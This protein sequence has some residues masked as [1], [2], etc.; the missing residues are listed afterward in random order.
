M[1]LK[2]YFNQLPHGSKHEFAKQLGITKTWLSLIIS[3][4]KMPSLRLVDAIE[5]LTNKKVT[6]VDLR[7]DIYG[8]K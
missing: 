5:K 2:D 3:G 7:T 1:N 4:K 8:R 6:L